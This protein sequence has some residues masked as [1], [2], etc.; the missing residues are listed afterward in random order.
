M[1]LYTTHIPHVP[2]TQKWPHIWGARTRNISY[3]HIH[4]SLTA[5]VPHMPKSHVDPK[6]HSCLTHSHQY[7]IYDH[8][9]PI[10]YT[11]A[12]HTPYLKHLYNEIHTF[13][14]Y[15]IHM[16]TPSTPE[17]HSHNV[18]MFIFLQ[19]DGQMS[20]LDLFLSL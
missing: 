1:L 11:H 20:M 10:Q 4:T 16:S 13:I 7:V 18:L 15:S 2:H 5:C 6:L 17:I 3:S 9:I 12:T 14:F 19:V 8:I